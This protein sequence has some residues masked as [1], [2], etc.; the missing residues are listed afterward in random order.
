MDKPLRITILPSSKH[1]DSP[2]AF[3]LDYPPGVY[4][5]FLMSSS[6]NADAKNPESLCILS[7]SVQLERLF[8]SNADSNVFESGQQLRHDLA[9]YCIDHPPPQSSAASHHRTVWFVTVLVVDVTTHV[10]VQLLPYTGL[11]KVTALDVLHPV[12]R[13]SPSPDAA[14]QRTTR[15][16]SL[17]ASS[18]RP[19]RLG[20]KLWMMSRDIT[21][22]PLP[23]HVKHSQWIRD[24]NQLLLDVEPG[25]KPREPGVTYVDHVL[26]DPTTGEILEGFVSNVFVLERIDRG[27][28][29]L[30][31]SRANET[32]L[33]GSIRQILVDV[34]V[35]GIRPPGSN[36]KDHNVR[37]P[38]VIQQ[39]DR[40]LTLVELRDKLSVEL[41]FITN[42]RRL[43]EPIAQVHYDDD[44][45]DLHP[46]VLD[47]RHSNAQHWLVQRLNRDLVQYIQDKLEILN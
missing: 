47:F 18:P 11:T 24:R 43:V 42:V 46:R 30:W 10:I 16:R 2:R 7:W 44:Q 4:S 1:G 25:K 21:K 5:C 13:P 14:G 37:Q 36:V 45:H 39:M 38:R 20:S 6:A 34:V 22:T 23:R 33:N 35:P 8:R 9:Q 19:S 32:I 29:R 3:L 15:V 31:T 27:S 41:V 12:E 28:Y 40:G 26:L 17:S